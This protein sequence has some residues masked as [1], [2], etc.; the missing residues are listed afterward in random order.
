[1]MRATGRTPAR[2]TKSLIDARRPYL[3]ADHIAEKFTKERMIDPEDAHFLWHNIPLWDTPLYDIP[4]R[5]ANAPSKQAK[6]DTEF[7]LSADQV[8]AIRELLETYDTITQHLTPGSPLNPDTIAI[9]AA[10][11]LPLSTWPRLIHEVRS[12]QKTLGHGTTIRLS[13]LCQLFQGA[14]NSGLKLRD[15][16]SRLRDEGINEILPG[17]WHHDPLS[18]QQPNLLIQPPLPFHIWLEIQQDVAAAGLTSSVEIDLAQP[19][20]SLISSLS[21]VRQMQTQTKHFTQLRWQLSRWPNEPHAVENIL[22]KAWITRRFLHNF[23]HFSVAVNRPLRAYLAMFLQQSGY[24]ICQRIVCPS[25]VQSSTRYQHDTHIKRPWS[26]FLADVRKSSRSIQIQMR[27]YHMQSQNRDNEIEAKLDPSLLLY[28]AEKG[29]DLSQDDIVQLVRTS[30]LYSLGQ[31]CDTLNKSPSRPTLTVWHQPQLDWIPVTT[32]PK[33][34]EHRSPN[35]CVFDFSHLHQAPYF[36]FQ[37]FLDEVRTRKQRDPEF[38]FSISGLKGFWQSSRQS[39]TDFQTI[40]MELKKRGLCLVSSSADETEQDLTHSEIAK[41]H[42]TL[43]HSGIDSIG[44][45][46][47]AAPFAGDEPPFWEQ[48]CQRLSKFQE[49]AVESKHLMAVAINIAPGCRCSLDEVL[50]GLAIARIGF[51]RLDRIQMWM[52]PDSIDAVQSW[53]E[54]LYRVLPLF[55][56]F[57]MNDCNWNKNQACNEAIQEPMKALTDMGYNPIV[58]SFSEWPA[59]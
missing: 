6:M 36:H 17:V 35:P 26:Q 25:W 19:L 52:K 39:S 32:L 7:V 50:R 55:L 56:H 54:L 31:C 8:M 1:M 14:W 43:H 59:T 30:S 28:K 48:Y 20:E 41:I 2:L 34:A 29:E 27:H 11:S 16:L 47:I 15:Y 22:K 46:E 33:L 21:L 51:H 44:Q 9:N 23:D 49:I 53:D 45:V 58:R 37:H 5:Q 42:Q 3:T 24:N 40:V 57:G 38:Q 10:P 12:V 13:D 18:N 4:N